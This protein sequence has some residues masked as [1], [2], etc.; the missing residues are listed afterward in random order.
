[1][2]IDENAVDGRAARWKR[3][4]RFRGVGALVLLAALCLCCLGSGLPS[5]SGTPVGEHYPTWVVA[6]TWLL[7]TPSILAVP[8]GAWLLI[9]GAGSVLGTVLRVVGVLL[10]V[11]TLGLGALFGLFLHTALE[12]PAPDPSV[13]HDDDGG[14]FDWD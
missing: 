4:R 10:V 13:H 7:V 3:E 2:S 8:V 9:V 5:V 12:A 1:M 14:G 6:S 11:G